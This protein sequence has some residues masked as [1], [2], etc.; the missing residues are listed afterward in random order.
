VAGPKAGRRRGRGRSRGRL[1]QLGKRTASRFGTNAGQAVVPP[2][3]SSSF[4]FGFPAALQPTG[5]LQTGQQ[6][7]ERSALQAGA[8]DQFEA[9]VILGRLGEHHVENLQQRKGDPW[10]ARHVGSL[11][12][13][14]NDAHDVPGVSCRCANRRWL[15][16][17]WLAAT[18]TSSDRGEVPVTGGWG[19]WGG[20]S[21][22]GR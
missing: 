17:A 21:G 20:G 5:G 12:R 8:L 1:R 19:G 7:V 10:F 14:T 2:P 11:H 22:L 4:L 16:G 18:P 3:G 9:P 6:R 13:S 15:Y